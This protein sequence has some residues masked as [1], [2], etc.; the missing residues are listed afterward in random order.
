MASN[1]D[2]KE[3]TQMTRV[4]TMPERIKDSRTPSAL[5]LSKKFESEEPKSWPSM[6]SLAV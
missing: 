5:I 4:K 2:R 1:S 6:D 3:K